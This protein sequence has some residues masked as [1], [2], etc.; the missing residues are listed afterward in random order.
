MPKTRTTRMSTVAKLGRRTLTLACYCMVGCRS[1]HTGA[2]A[3]GGGRGEH[4]AL[5]GLDARE[6]RH[7]TG[8]GVAGEDDALLDAVAAHDEDAAGALVAEQRALGDHG[9]LFRADA[10]LGAREH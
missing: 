5:F 7:R 10:E 6:D 8:L 2:V 9:Q 4:D 3:E 1:L